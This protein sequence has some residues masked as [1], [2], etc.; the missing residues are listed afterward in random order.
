MLYNH[1]T[2]YIPPPPLKNIAADV[3]GKTKSPRLNI[4]I[5]IVG[6]RGDVQPFLAFG[7]ELKC[8]GHRVRLATHA[9]FKDFVK[10][11]GL[12]FYPLAG[13][14]AELMAYMVKNPGLLPSISSIAAGDIG[15]KRRQIADILESS[16]QACIDTKSDDPDAEPFTVDAIISNPPVFAHVHISERLNVPLHIYFTMPWSPTRAFP[17]PLTTV[18]PNPTLAPRMNYISYEI[19]EMMTWQGLGDIINDFRTKILNL[20]PLGSSGAYI[21]QQLKIPHTYCWSPGLIPKP[22]DWGKH[23]DI[24]GFFFLDE[25]NQNNYTPP[26]DLARFLRNGEKPVYIGFGSIVIDDPDKL[27]KTLLTAVKKSGVR[28]II[29][30]GWSGIG[31][32]KEDTNED[33]FFI[34]AVPHDWLFLHV[35]AVCHHG[36]AG[37]TAAGL[38]A[39]LP[40]IIVPFFG[41][42]PFWGAMCASMGVGP[43]PIPHQKLTVARLVK[44]FEVALDPLTVA[45]AKDL[46]ERLRQEQGALE[47]L[48]SFHRHLPANL[49]CCE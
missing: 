16:W 42:Q 39:G 24:C 34:D 45:R 15:K 43:A 13:D 25:A 38:R 19:L 4:L 10:K 6:S 48:R 35:A 23:I 44:A 37:T 2:S 8:Y 14:P 28:A 47:G 29:S 27:T 9:N 3:P 18:K 31:K 30:K 5:L 12:E 20:E 32:G 49:V 36:G 41:D 26:D 21:M 33:I 11:S 46:G 22:V 7:K 40:T 17:H 1:S